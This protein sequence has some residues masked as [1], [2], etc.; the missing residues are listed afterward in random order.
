[1]RRK[2][3]RIEHLEGASAYFSGSEELLPSSFR[4]VPT[5]ITVNFYF[6][7]TLSP[8]GCCT[9]YPISLIISPVPFCYIYS[10]N[11]FSSPRVSK[12]VSACMG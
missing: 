10:I 9:Q 11:V 6:W 2:T 5:S 1:V 7:Y 12:K 4:E 8:V 3:Q